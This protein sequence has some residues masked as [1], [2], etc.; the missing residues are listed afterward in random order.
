MVT[1]TISTPKDKTTGLYVQSL[2]LSIGDN[3]PGLYQSCESRRREG[4]AEFLRVVS[5]MI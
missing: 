1:R 2:D 5:T 4:S 3:K